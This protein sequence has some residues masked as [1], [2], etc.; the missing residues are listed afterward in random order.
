MRLRALRR[1]FRASLHDPRHIP[2]TDHYAV[3]IA[4]TEAMVQ[5]S[6]DFEAAEFYDITHLHLRAL[7]VF[8]FPALRALAFG[9]VVLEGMAPGAYGEHPTSQRLA[10]I[11]DGD[12]LGRLPVERL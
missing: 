8:R 7:E 12:D 3:L 1:S 2:L 9:A 10:L 6:A 5:I 4:P 11:G